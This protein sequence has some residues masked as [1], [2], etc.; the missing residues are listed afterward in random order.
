MKADHCSG[1]ASEIPRDNP[2]VALAT[3]GSSAKKILYTLR[4]EELS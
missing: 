3:Q 4:K 2:E 1:D